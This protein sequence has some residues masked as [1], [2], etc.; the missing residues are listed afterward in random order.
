M[1]QAFQ[2]QGEIFVEIA[3]FFFIDEQTARRH[4]KDYFDNDKTGGSS[5]GSEGK[6][7]QDQAARLR[8]ILAT[9]D[10]P[11]DQTAVEKVKSLFS[12]QFSISGMT[13][14]LNR[15]RFSFKKSDPAPAKACPL[16]QA[17]FIDTYHGLKDGLPEGEVV[18]FLDAAHPTRA[19]K[20]G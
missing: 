20:L 16:S 14:W 18:L 17:E 9:F 13:D 4:L 19:T 8:A 7:T 11:T 6:L 5:D 15:N 10:V 12:I 3:K 2:Q 1:T